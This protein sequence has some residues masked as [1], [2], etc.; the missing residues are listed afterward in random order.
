MK[1]IL[2]CFSGTGNTRWVCE[3]FVEEGRRRGWVD[4]LLVPVTRAALDDLGNLPL[5]EF[6]LV[7]LAHPVYGADLPPLVRD[8]VRALEARLTRPVEAFVI[9]TYG[10]VNGL[11]YWAERKSFRHLKIRQYINVRMPNNITTPQ[12][13]TPVPGPPEVRRR[14]EQALPVLRR[15]WDRILRG[16]RWITGFGPWLLAGTVIRRAAR[17]GIAGFYRQLSADPARCTLCLTCLE[18]C[19]A[20]AV[21][22]EGR[23]LRF[24]AACTACTRC[25]NTCPTQAI[26]I[27]GTYADPHDY[28]RYVLA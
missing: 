17:K 6:D 12:V 21:S 13:R 18:G 10:F 14:L 19:P 5:G 25:Y 8:L 7:G 24:S 27:G 15:G 22:L 3:R 23:H 11:G 20:G 1:A 2:F 28:P 16:R 9:A 26:L 4:T